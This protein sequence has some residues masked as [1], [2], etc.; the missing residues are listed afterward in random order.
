MDKSYY[1]DEIEN[2]ATALYEEGWRSDDRDELKEE[3]NLDNEWTDAICKKL[4]EYE[5]IDKND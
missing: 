4:K 1:T 3:Y 2:C 5:R